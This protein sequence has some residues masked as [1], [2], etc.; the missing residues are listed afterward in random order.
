MRQIRYKY[1]T[2]LE[3]LIAMALTSLVLMALT[4]FYQQVTII[5][6]EADKV[7]SEGFYIRYVENRLME[8]IPKIIAKNDKSGDF[9]FFSF[10]NDGL[11]LPGSQGL[12]FTFDNGICF[13]RL[14]SNHVIGRLLVDPKG[15]LLLFYWPM[16]KRLKDK[17]DIPVKKEVLLTGVESLA[18]EFFVAPLKPKETIK[19]DLVPGAWHRRLWQQE[20]GLLPVMVKMMITLSKTPERQIFVFP[21]TKNNNHIIYE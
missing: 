15:D 8:V 4:F 14:F 1:V 10:E 3:L 11:G 17:N 19:E 13:D 12:V 20:S 21:L 6:S 9:L 16:P 5:G 2:L 18:F 7:R